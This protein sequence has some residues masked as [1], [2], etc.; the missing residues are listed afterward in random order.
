MGVGA[1]MPNHASLHHYNDDHGTTSASIV[2]PYLLEYIDVA[3]VI[4]IGCGPGQWPYVFQTYGVKEAIGIDGAHVPP[5][6]RKIK[7]FHEFD[8]SD[9][10]GLKNFLRATFSASF[11][12]CLSLEVAEHLPAA[13]ARDFIGML[14]DLSDCVLF[15]A[16]I[17]YQT[18]ENHINEQPHEY[19]HS[20]FA[21]R[22]FRCCDIFRKKFWN[23]P[24]V[25]WW[26]RQNMFLYTSESC[27]LKKEI[28][29][30]YDG[31]TYV[32]PE[33]LKLYIPAPDNRPQKNSLHRRILSKLKSLT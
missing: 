27:R 4:D 15:S 25:N 12:L 1:V 2:I 30:P 11:D 9:I 16:A 5:E 6:S 32:H 23:N 8:L 33:L 13:I 14:T 24:S 19:W 17:P 7:L 18:G 3:S 28:D 26:Y 31:N 22:G 10:P 20:L 21:E 29:C